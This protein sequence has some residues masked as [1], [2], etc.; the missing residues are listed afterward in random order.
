MI[1]LSI[2]KK[3]KLA[4]VYCGDTLEAR[5]EWEGSIASVEEVC[6]GYI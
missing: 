3:L 2:L 1:W 5:T 4:M 6:G